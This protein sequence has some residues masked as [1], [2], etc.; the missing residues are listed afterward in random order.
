MLTVFGDRAR[1]GRPRVSAGDHHL[2]VRAAT[3]AELRSRTTA[4]I[5]QPPIDGCTVRVDFW[6]PPQRGWLG[7]HAL[8]GV[9][10]ISVT[11]K[12]DGCVLEINLTKPMDPAVVLSACLRVL[13]PAPTGASGPQ[14][15]WAPG[16][17]SH[18]YLAENVF[19]ISTAE[20]D[21]YLQ[22]FDVLLRGGGVGEVEA[23]TSVDVRSSVW[24]GH[25]VFVDPLVHRPI[26]RKQLGH[27][28]SVNPVV[29][30]VRDLN[31]PAVLGDADVARV[32]SVAAIS[33]PQEL[34]AQQRAQLNACGVITDQQL[35]AADDLLAWNAG[36]ASAVRQAMLF[37]TPLTALDA[38]PS[39]SIIMSTHRADHLA[40]AL[41]MVRRQTYPYLQ[42]IIVQHGSVELPVRE[43]LADWDGEWAVIGLPD[44]LTLGHCLIEA[45]ARADGDLITKMDDDDYYGPDHIWDLVLARMYSGA[46]VVG[47][48]LDYVYLE[49]SDT[50]VYRPVYGAEQYAKFVAGGT[51]LISRGD[52]ATVG[53]WRPVPR[54]VDRALLDRVMQH[55]GLVYRTH[56]LG[57][58]YVRHAISAN[59]SRVTDEHFLGRTRQTFPGLLQRSELGTDE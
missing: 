9:A 20:R 45:S 18:G 24:N 42:L 39:V 44:E 32:I 34:T 19:D 23:G 48:S 17:D 6:R 52:L 37:H 58:T 25:E 40:H 38:W 21:E 13:A 2:N 49:G 30:S 28:E 8:P 36:S 54:S 4:M 51:M 33:D 47:K 12:G 35:P 31:L 59:T 57:Y 26:G 5:G 7:H 29:S 16:A 14:L 3:I 56:G 43:L 1:G 22:N 11:P 50:T 15:T 53:G 10:G 41:A 55:G 27:V 46:Q